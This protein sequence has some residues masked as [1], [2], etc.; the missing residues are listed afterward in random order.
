V[1]ENNKPIFLR[2]GLLGEAVASDHFFRKIGDAMNFLQEK[3][4]F[5]QSGNGPT[6]SYSTYNVL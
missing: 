5:D 2:S 3:W 1:R 4:E 6:T